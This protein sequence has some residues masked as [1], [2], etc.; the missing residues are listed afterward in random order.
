M[1]TPHKTIDVCLSNPIAHGLS[2]ANTFAVCARTPNTWI[3]SPETFEE[4]DQRKKDQQAAYYNKR[5]L[6]V[7]AHCRGCRKEINMRSYVVPLD[8]GAVLRR[9]HQQI[10]AHLQIWR[11]KTRSWTTRT[12][13]ESHSL[14]MNRRLTEGS[15]RRLK[16]LG[17]EELSFCHYGERTIP[18]ERKVS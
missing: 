14:G 11:L 7:R 17:L 4:L 1:S 12:I 9:N 6:M 5:I 15:G 8:G 13:Q 2:A 18:E 10:Y 16:V 3:D